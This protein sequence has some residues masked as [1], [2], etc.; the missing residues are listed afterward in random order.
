M[1]ATEITVQALNKA[2]LDPS[3]ASANVDGNF[4]LN[5]DRTELIVNNG[6]AGSIDVTAAAQ[7]TSMFQEGYGTITL[8]NNV[9]AVAA[10]AEKLITFPPSIFND[11]N[12]KVQ[13]TYSAVASV[14]V[15]V[16]KLDPM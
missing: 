8:G 12:G 10:G 14:T 7:K 16:V 3:M 6:S 13:L 5:T 15:G 9:V 2:G 1:A 11:G 4:F